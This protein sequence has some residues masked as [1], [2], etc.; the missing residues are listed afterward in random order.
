[1]TTKRDLEA[2]QVATGRDM[3]ALEGRLG[4]RMG[5]LEVQMEALGGRMGAL[6]T[7]V[8]VRIEASEH[9]V[10]GCLERQMRL[11]TWRLVTVIV[12][13]AAMVTAGTRL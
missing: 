7:T 13:V 1:V 9:K 3:G 2:L 10:L 6:E 5:A 8:Q 4:G 11:Q 12:A